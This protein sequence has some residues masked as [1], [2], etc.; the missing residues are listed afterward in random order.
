MELFEKG[1]ENGNWDENQMKGEGKR[2]WL[3][4]RTEISKE[5]HLRDKL[6]TWT[7]GCF[8]ESGG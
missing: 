4:M 5:K 6:E 1:N 8:Q 2:I 7:W 3:G